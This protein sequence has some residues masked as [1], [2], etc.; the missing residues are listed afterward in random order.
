MG[1]LAAQ[2][3]HTALRM[4]QHIHTLTC[5]TN[6]RGSAQIHAIMIW[7]NLVPFSTSV[8]SPADVLNNGILQVTSDFIA[9]HLFERYLW[10]YMDKRRVVPSVRQNA[11]TELWTLS[12]Q[13]VHCLVWLNWEPGCVKEAAGGTGSVSG[14][15]GTAGNLH[16]VVVDTSK[17]LSGQPHPVWFTEEIWLM[18]P[19]C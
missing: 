17:I 10:V 3:T 8:F 18:G 16:S 6:Q 4:S 13:E 1:W 2:S 12:F 11:H 19:C 5:V 7:C 14:L 15:W 9:I